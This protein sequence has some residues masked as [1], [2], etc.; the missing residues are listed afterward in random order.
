VYKGHVRVKVKAKVRVEVKVKVK[1]S[2]GLQALYR[3]AGVAERA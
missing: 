1:G 3:D 2:S